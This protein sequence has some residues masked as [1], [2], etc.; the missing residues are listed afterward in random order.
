MEGMFIMILEFADGS[1]LEV[2]VIFGDTIIDDDEIERDALTIDIDPNIATIEELKLI[3]NDSTKTDH[4]YTYLN[5]DGINQ[6]KT[7]IGE[8]YNKF[9]YAVNENKLV[10]QIPGKITKKQFQ[11]VNSVRIAKLTYDEY[12]PEDED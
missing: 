2:L 8:G 11:N 9:I 12:Y 10:R 3:F 1:Q 6:V 7:E 4:L 5:N